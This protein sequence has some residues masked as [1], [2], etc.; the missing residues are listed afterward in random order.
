MTHT[1]THSA[2]AYFAF[3]LGERYAYNLYSEVMNSRAHRTPWLTLTIFLKIFLKISSQC[4]YNSYCLLKKKL[5]TNHNLQQKYN[6]WH[7]KLFF[8]L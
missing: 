6:T 7:L 4:L 5:N 3:V 2:V 1:L 8:L